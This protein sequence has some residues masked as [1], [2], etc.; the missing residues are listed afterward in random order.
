MSQFF[1]VSLG[2][3]GWYFKERGVAEGEGGVV[4]GA[5]PRGCGQNLKK[6]FFFK[7]IV[8]MKKKHKF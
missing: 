5:W 2:E 8:T 7:K 1:L 3:E 4:K 6:Y